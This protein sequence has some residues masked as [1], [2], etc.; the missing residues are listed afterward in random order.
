[1]AEENSIKSRFERDGSTL[2]VPVSPNTNPSTPESIDVVGNST[3]HNE[4]SNIGTPE[5]NTAPYTNFGASAIAY[6]TP[7]TSQLGELAFGQ[8]EPSNR[9]KNN[10]ET[11][12][13]IV[14]SKYT[15]PH[16]EP[17]PIPFGV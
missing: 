9:Y 1:M 3:L 14:T 4:Y 5:S 7:K 11:K 16:I 8:Q 6:S 17:K 15:N 10:M 13:F 12:Y 2:A